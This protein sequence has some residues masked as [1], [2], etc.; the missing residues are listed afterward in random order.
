MYRTHYQD[1]SEKTPVPLRNY[2]I[3]KYAGFIP[4]KEGN[5]ELGRSYTKI[6]RRCINKEEE[7]QKTSDRFRSTDFKS[8]QRAFDKTRP[9]F[10]RG[11]GKT[12]M[13]APHPCLNEEWST[14]FRKTYLKPNTRTKPN[15]HTQL[16]VQEI[17]HDNNLNVAS[18]T[19]T[20]ASGFQANSQLF[21]ET[22]WRTEANTH[23]DIIRTE[24]RNRY[25]QAKPFH[26]EALVNSHG[27]IK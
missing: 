9:N 20:I 16:P 27:R 14:S 8:D 21:D 11:Y 5:S 6:T 22:S 13:L 1:M 19:S 10:F 7:F 3:P 12:T 15:A 4:G 24:Y 18:R 17:E 26:K 23:T 2:A 25:N